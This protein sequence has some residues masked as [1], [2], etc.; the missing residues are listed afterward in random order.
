MTISFQVNFILNLNPMRNIHITNSKNVLRS[1]SLT[2][3]HIIANDIMTTH[4][5]PTLHE[6]CPY[7]RHVAGCKA[8]NFFFCPTGK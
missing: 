2:L 6:M 8:L 7:L 1:K 5:A 3:T 4:S